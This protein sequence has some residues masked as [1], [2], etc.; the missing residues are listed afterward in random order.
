MM[1]SHQIIILSGGGFFA[2]RN[3]EIGRPLA[4]GE[5]DPDGITQPGVEGGMQLPAAGSARPTLPAKGF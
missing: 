3:S 2:K 1:A 4:S 5:P